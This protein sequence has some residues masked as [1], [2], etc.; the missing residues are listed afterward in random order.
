V[1][2]SGAASSVARAELRDASGVVVGEVVFKRREGEIVGQ[3]EVQLPT[4]GAEFHGF[5]IHANADGLGCVAPAF[6]S[7]GGHWD[8]GTH[9][10]GAHLGDL[11]V[12]M[13][14]ASGH[15]EAE[16]VV[17][18]LTPD[19]IIGRAVIVHVGAD[20]YANIPALYGTPDAN[21]TLK[22]GDAGGRYACGVIEPRSG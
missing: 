3:A 7:V 2:T 19:D 18:K 4:G 12:L 6:T 5:H 9:T 14:D 10:H 15:A 11:P 21:T 1:G 22:T 13:R 16:V 8:D 20:N 17:G